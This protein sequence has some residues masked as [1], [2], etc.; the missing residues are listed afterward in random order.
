MPI[1]INRCRRVPQAIHLQPPQHHPDRPT[2]PR[3]PWMPFCDLVELRALLLQIRV[4]HWTLVLQLILCQSVSWNTLHIWTFQ[5][6]STERAIWFTYQC[7]SFSH[8][9]KTFGCSDVGL[10]SGLSQKAFLLFATLGTCSVV[11]Y[12]TPS[13]SQTFFHLIKFVICDLASPSTR[14]RSCWLRD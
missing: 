12:S 11:Q 3:D 10:A 4:Q 14:R 9:R 13:S 5:A 1:S 7:L 6:Y 8:Q 2:I